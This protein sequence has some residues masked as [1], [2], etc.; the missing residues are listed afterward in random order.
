MA[1]NPDSSIKWIGIKRRPL[2]MVVKSA[3]KTGLFIIFNIT[4]MSRFAGVGEPLEE[5]SDLGITCPLRHSDS[6]GD[7]V[8]PAVLNWSLKSCM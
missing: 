6:S 1:V 3:Q 2:M 8:Q 7:H 4:S 5:R